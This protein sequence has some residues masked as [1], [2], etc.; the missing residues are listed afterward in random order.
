MTANDGDHEHIGQTK[1]QFG[2]SLKEHQKA[3]F[4]YQKQEK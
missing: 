2:T 4:F 1:R 3:V